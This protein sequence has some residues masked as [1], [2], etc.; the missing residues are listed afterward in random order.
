[1]EADVGGDYT[2]DRNLAQACQDVVNIA[3]RHIALKSLTVIL[4]IPVFRIII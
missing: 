1:M 4:Y 3:C 2:M